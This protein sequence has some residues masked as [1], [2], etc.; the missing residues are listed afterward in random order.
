MRAGVGEDV[1]GRVVADEGFVDAAHVATLGG[2]RVEF[3]V[4]VGASAAFAEAVVGVF[5]DGAEVGAIEGAEIEA[6]R[7]D[8]LA[9]IDDDRRDAHARELVG[10]EQAA[11]A[12]AHDDDLRLAV[13][14]GGYGIAERRRIGRRQR[15]D[16]H[17]E[18][19]APRAVS[20]GVDGAAHDA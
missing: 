7:I 3:A 8:G 5:V 1:G 19:H 9:A 11:R 20:T 4:G 10:A 14:F 6:A 18:A 2:A 16:E 15:R 17:M 13:R 12:V